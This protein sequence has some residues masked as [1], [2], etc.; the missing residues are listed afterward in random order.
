MTISHSLPQRPG[1]VRAQGNSPGAS[2]DEREACRQVHKL[3]MAAAEALGASEAITSG[4]GPTPT[5]IA[6][7]DRERLALFF[8]H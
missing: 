7:R 1:V 6:A 5:E 3:V 4:D 8:F 2:S